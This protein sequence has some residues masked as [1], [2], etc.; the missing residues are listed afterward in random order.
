MEIVR[1][2]SSKYAQHAVVEV[3]D[4]VRAD[5]L[6]DHLVVGRATGNKAFLHLI[7]RINGAKRAVSAIY[8]VQVGCVR[9]RFAA[10]SAEACSHCLKVRLNLLHDR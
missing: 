3:I 10:E 7:E 9:V 8:K 6:E 2:A 4:D 1:W 5:S